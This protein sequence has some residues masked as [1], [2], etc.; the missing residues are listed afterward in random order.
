MTRFFL[1]PVRCTAALAFVTALAACGD[2]SDDA[3]DAQSALCNDGEIDWPDEQE[4]LWNN[5]EVT[6]VNREAARAWFVTAHP[7]VGPKE[8]DLPDTGPATVALDGRWRYQFSASPSSLPAGF[9]SPDFDDSDWD[10]IGVPSNVEMLG[11]GEPIYLNQHYPFDPNRES[12]FDFP[13]IPAENNSVSS[14]R[15]DFEVP[16]GWD[17]RSVFIRFEGVDSAFYLWLNGERVGYSQGSRTPAEFDLT[18]FL[19]EG[20]NLLAVQV[21]RWS[22]GTWLEKQDMWNL[23]G[24][25]REVILWSAGGSY[26]RDF[27]VQTELA[28][29]FST[30][31]LSVSADI[32]RLVDREVGTTVQVSLDGSESEPVTREIALDPCG[33]GRLEFDIAVDNPALWS[34]E[35]PNLY[36]LSIALGDEDGNI[37]LIRQQVGFRDVA[38]ENGQLLVNGR[39]ILVRGANRHEHNPFTG[40]YVTE[41]EMITDLEL[42]KQNNFNAVRPGHYPL[43][44]RWYELANEYG[45]Y[46]V[47]EANLETHGLWM[48]E[49]I[50]LGTFP[51]WEAN[52][53]ERVERMLER[54]KNQPSVIAW[55]MGNEAAD[56]PTF[57]NI[58]DWLHERDPSRP[59]FYEG[60]N[61]GGEGIV[62]D[63]S[64]VQCPMYWTAQLVEDYVSEPQPRPIILI[65]YAHA[66]GNSTGNMREFWDVFHEY[67]QAQGGFVW[68][69][70]DQGIRIPIPG[71]DGETFVAYGGDIGP[72][73][74]DEELNAIT[75][76]FGNN[77]CMNGLLGADQD[78]HPGLAT[79]K[80]VMQPVDAE[81]VDLATGV[82]RIVNRYDHSVLTSQVTA[83]WMVEVDG[84]E[85]ER[86]ELMLPALAPGS[87]EELTVPFAEPAVPDGAEA[88]LRIRFV[89]VDDAIWA[90]A[91]HEVAWS[92]FALPFGA[93]GPPIDASSANPLVVSQDDDIVIDSDEFGV[94]IDAATGALTSLRRDGSERLAEPLRP[95]F[96][97]PLTDNDF[98]TSLDARASIWETAGTSMS[99]TAL[100]VNTDSATETI[101][102]AQLES[103]GIDA[104]FEVVYRVFA[105]GEIGVRL[106]F[107]PAGSL[108]ELPRFGMRLAMDESFDR[109]TWYGPGPESSYPDRNEQPVLLN[110]GRVAD[111]PVA[112]A[113]P[114]ESGN[115]TDVRFIAVRD[116]TGAGLLA[117]G[118]P[119][120]SVNVLPYSTEAIAAAAHPFEI[121]NDDMTHVNLD[122]IQRGVGGDNSW[123]RPPLDP[124]IVDAV[125]QDYEMWIRPLAEGD[126][127]VALSRQ[128][129][130]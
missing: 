74:P 103:D 60:S 116:D 92:D 46:V 122:R 94:T 9:E 41:E 115:K 96:W 61:R 88:R 67:D 32:R 129:L 82:V 30:G 65:E 27:E 24:I 80:H 117:V 83:E 59:V 75:R 22:D 85:V 26:I 76:L 11:Y 28:D 57:D 102:T 73:V 86:G 39:P 56:G 4:P 14:Y 128:T 104:V 108:A 1:R 6:S 114:Q 50:D 33:D 66:M 35:N 126:D 95:D 7:E 18:P 81:A 52:H 111:Q 110:R 12:A 124:Y 120:L 90:D 10:D 112:Y 130:P 123:G 72:G 23:S 68:D 3:T 91:G 37:E 44:P 64:D 109:V 97:R 25:F 36:T 45:I 16:A 13:E 100:D 55:S 119:W 113:R 84:D 40:H 17:G 19:V 77:F 105:T 98:G 125:A 29:D 58:S 107:S 70:I 53:M 79:M 34:A 43:T 38:I 89:T 99:V 8:I 101:V 31:V 121:A 71:G 5:F 15:R 49:G 47:D 21:Y 42:L 63:H 54:D 2:G 87:T 106:G 20:E 118:S 62:A 48:F 93:A 51:E 78:P 69:W 127:P